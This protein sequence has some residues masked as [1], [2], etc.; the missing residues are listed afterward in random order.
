VAV[1]VF[2]IFA[3]AVIF[4]LLASWVMYRREQRRGHEC[5]TLM[6]EAGPK[7]AD[8]RSANGALDSGVRVAVTP[9]MQ[10]C[11]IEVRVA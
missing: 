1:A 11:R 4:V 8:V 5:W 9:T 7:S 10:G 6:T 3:A 2:A